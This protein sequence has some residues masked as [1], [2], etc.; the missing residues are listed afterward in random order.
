MS[1]DKQTNV[2]IV[3]DDIFLAEIYQKK[4]EMEGFKTTVANNGEKGLAE[5][6]N[7]IA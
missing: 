7:C 4:F 6:K 1:P 3:E 5:I 2:L